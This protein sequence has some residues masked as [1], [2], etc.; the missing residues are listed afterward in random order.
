MQRACNKRVRCAAAVLDQRLRVLT[1]FVTDL[2]AG[3]LLFLHHHLLQLG[4]SSVTSDEL[5]HVRTHLQTG[6]INT[7]QCSQ[8]LMRLRSQVM[9]I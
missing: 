9:F 2:E 7:S 1:S 3:S 5:F 8:F 6:T 4:L